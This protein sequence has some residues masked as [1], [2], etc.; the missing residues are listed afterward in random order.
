[1]VKFGKSGLLVLITY[2]VPLASAKARASSKL[3][4]QFVTTYQPHDRD[5]ANTGRGVLS[6]ASADEIK[7]GAHAIKT[8]IVSFIVPH[9]LC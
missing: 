2:P 7:P 1:L 5:A 9:H 8:P 6:L 3:G 4:L